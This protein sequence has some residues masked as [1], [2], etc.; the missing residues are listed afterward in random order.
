M[1]I[2]VSDSRS[3]TRRTEVLVIG[4]GQAGLAAAN[5]LKKAGV[6]Y[7]MVD[8]GAAVGD[9]WRQRYETLTLFTPRSISSLPGLPLPGDTEGYATKD[10]FAAYLARY[11]KVG[12]HRIETGTRI[13]AL[14]R[15]HGVFEAVSSDGRIYAAPAVIV[16]GTGHRFELAFM[17]DDDAAVNRLY[18][19][20]RAAGVA[21]E[22]EPSVAVF[23][24]TFVALDP[25][26]HRLRVC[27]PDE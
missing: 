12:G 18:D 2:D 14:R 16:S 6:D 26:G 5:E 3:G 19:T 13:S 17:V 24:R 27:T 23:G 15:E 11:A 4:A 21:I 9:S 10:E 1:S 7:L 20:W 8:A 25:D 22:Q